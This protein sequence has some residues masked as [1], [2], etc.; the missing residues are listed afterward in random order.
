MSGV[1]VR[2]G[3][4]FDYLGERIPEDGGDD[5]L[6]LTWRFAEEH[7]LYY[8][9]LSQLLQ[10]TGG[11]CDCEVLMNSAEYISDDEVIGEETFVTPVRY[12]IEHGMYCHERLAG[13]PISFAD[14]VAA[15]EAGLKVEWHVPC[16]KDAPFAF[17]DVTRAAEAIRNGGGE[18]N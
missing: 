6:D 15:K 4:L 7:G 1:K 2:Y 13:D 18:S 3:D 12:A 17:P 5:T 10:E 11:Y 16:G 14:A 9:E 8:G